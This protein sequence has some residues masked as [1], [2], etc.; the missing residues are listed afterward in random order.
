MNEEQEAADLLGKRKARVSYGATKDAG[1]DRFMARGKGS[2]NI[3]VDEH[4]IPLSLVFI[5]STLAK[6]FILLSN[7]RF[8]DL[9]LIIQSTNLHAEK[10]CRIFDL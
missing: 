3:P 10:T 1:Q 4:L 2:V 7:N 9:L 8:A 6:L 5:Y